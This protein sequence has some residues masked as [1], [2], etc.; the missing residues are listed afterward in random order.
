MQTK[1]ITINNRSVRYIDAGDP[2]ARPVIL[3]HGNVGD[4]DFHWQH[5]IPELADEY[6]IIAPD[7]PDYGQSAALPQNTFA[8]WVAW[9]EGF[10]AALDF[11][12][13]VLVGA[14]VGALVARLYAAAH[15]THVPALV[16]INGGGLPPKSP[17]MTKVLA[18]LPLVNNLIFGGASRQM[19]ASRE[20]LQWMVQH[21]KPPP[22]PNPDTKEDDD[23]HPQR[24]DI[25]DPI[26]EAMVETAQASA[27]A[28]ARLMRTQV[29]SPVPEKRTP[30]IPTLVLWGDQDTIAP[31]STGK[32]IH[33]AIP[34]SVFTTISGT[35]HVPHIEEPEIVGFQILSF[36]DNLDKPAT[37]DLPGAGMLG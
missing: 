21:P 24:Y 36:L 23:T 1:T 37:P 11:G 8:A 15:P 31:I 28:L 2:T 7:L 25:P 5:L 26:T 13:A 34:G 33:K 22:P 30:R 17:A 12:G 35:R 6:H 19:V 18:S 4:A 27:P 20:A 32:R 3:L 16:L 10:Y 9:L 14:S 29:L